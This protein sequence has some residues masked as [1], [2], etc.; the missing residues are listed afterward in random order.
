[1]RVLRAVVAVVAL[2]II[3]LGV[4]PDILLIPFAILFGWIP[5]AKRLGGNL[6]F[7]LEALSLFFG[8]SVLFLLGI[9][10]FLQQLKPWHLRWTLAISGGVALVLL[11]IMSIVGVAHQLGWILI[12]REPVFAQRDQWIRD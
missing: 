7:P 5:A 1:M 6:P 2:I 9:H 11:A 10:W 8:G 3:I 12:S 4:L